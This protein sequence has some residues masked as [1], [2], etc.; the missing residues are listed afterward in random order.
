MPLLPRRIFGYLKVA[1]HVLKCSRRLKHDGQG[2]IS[3]KDLDLSNIELDRIRNFSIIAHIDH[4]KSTVSSIRIFLFS[5]FSKLKKGQIIKSTVKEA[6]PWSM[7]L[8]ISK[9]D[10]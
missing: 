1:K 5:S 6:L 9:N 8:K 4:G 7:H 2:V 3:I 10:E